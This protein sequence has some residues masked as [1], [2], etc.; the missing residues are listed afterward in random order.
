MLPRVGM[1]QMSIIQLAVMDITREKDM[2]AG[3]V[4]WKVI[5]KGNT[6]QTKHM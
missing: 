5:M 6:M 4:A 2:A 1:M 3:L